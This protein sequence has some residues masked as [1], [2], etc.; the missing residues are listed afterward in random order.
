MV[1][2]GPIREVLT[3]LAARKKSHSQDRPPGRF[4]TLDIAT[5]G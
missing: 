4:F 2:G 3:L 5:F 1:F